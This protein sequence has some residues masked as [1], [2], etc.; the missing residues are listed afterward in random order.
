MSALALDTCDGCEGKDV[1]LTLPRHQ[2]RRQK[3]VYDPDMETPIMIYCD[4][5]LDSRIGKQGH[6]TPIQPSAHS[7]NSFIHCFTRNVIGIFQIP[8]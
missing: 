3:M 6:E 7:G 1:L 2:A 5:G 4:T 8:F